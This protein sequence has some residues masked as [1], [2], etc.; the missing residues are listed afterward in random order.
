M[1]SI[2]LSDSL[3]ERKAKEIGEENVYEKGNVEL[4]KRFKSTVL[5]PTAK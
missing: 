5:T 2:V 3:L 1:F 4:Y